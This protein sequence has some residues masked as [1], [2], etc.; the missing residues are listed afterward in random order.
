[1]VEGELGCLGSLETG[2]AGEEDGIGAEGTLSMDQLLTDTEEAAD[3]V[4]RTKVDA[5]AIDIGTSHGAYKFTKPPTG[6]V[7]SIK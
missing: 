6:D 7:L 4:R 1:S 5:L 2:Q 3:F